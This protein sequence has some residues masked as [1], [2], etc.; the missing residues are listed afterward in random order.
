VRVLVAVV[1]A[2]AVAGCT[3]ARSGDPFA[4]APRALS[5]EYLPGR[6]ASP[7]PAVARTSG[8]YLVPFADDAGLHAR[9]FADDGR[10]EDLLLGPGALVG[11]SGLSD[12][13][14]VAM[15]SPAG[16]AVHFLDAYG[17]NDQV[18]AV[19]LAGTPV[20]YVAGDGK[21]VILAAT[22][23]GEIAIDTPRPLFASAAIVDATGDVETIDLGQV[24]APPSLWG[25]ARGFVVAGARL[26]DDA[27]AMS[28]AP[29]E[30]IAAARV[31]RKPV[32]TPNPTGDTIS[33]DGTRWLALDAIAARALPTGGDTLL[34][35]Q[36]LEL[37]RLGADLTQR[38]RVPLSP[39]GHVVAAADS[40]LVFARDDAPG[41]FALLD[42]ATAEP[43]GDRIQILHSDL[44]S[45][46]VA[47]GAADVLFAW[48]V[49]GCSEIARVIP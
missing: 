7:S 6:A 26:V 1:I 42:S 40:A 31:F 8:S 14:A 38:S 12:G 46:S 3:S 16:L 25:D 11:T 21:R 29:G 5:I 33:L 27:G 24:G 23:G 34:E 13:F 10:I 49:S 48:N 9:I 39:G 19:P 43:R 41:D 44:D 45:I 30:Q 32:T 37:V 28:T 20:P 17:P 15:T 18:V 47:P 22:T 35:L 36:S 4:G 2:A